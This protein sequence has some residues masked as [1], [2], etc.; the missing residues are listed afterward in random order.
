MKERDPEQPAPWEQM[1]GDLGAKAHELGK[2]AREVAYAFAQVMR[3]GS[4]E[5]Q[6]Q[7]RKVLVAVRRDLYRILADGADPEGPENS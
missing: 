6:E 1:S 5:Q 3:A 4:E 2:I 7:A